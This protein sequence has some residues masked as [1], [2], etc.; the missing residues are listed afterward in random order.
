MPIAAGWTAPRVAGYTAGIEPIAHSGRVGMALRSIGPATADFF[1]RQ[2]VRA[3]KWRGKKVRLSGWLK[4][5]NVDGGAALWLRVDMANG[6]YVLDS[7]FELSRRPGWTRAEL[8]AA[9]PQDAIG[10]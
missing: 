10:I 8:V 1:I 5:D 6:D 9:V 4:L 3:D 7:A 2:R